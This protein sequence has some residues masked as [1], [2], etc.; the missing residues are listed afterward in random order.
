MYNHAERMKSDKYHN[1]T[2]ADG[3]VTLRNFLNIL[4]LHEADSFAPYSGEVVIGV[5]LLVE[6]S[7]RILVYVGEGKIADRIAYHRNDRRKPIFDAFFLAT[8]AGSA[9]WSKYLAVDMEARFLALYEGAF[10]CKPRCNR[11]FEHR[12]DAVKNRLS[13]RASVKQ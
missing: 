13:A 10:K 1:G 6:R 5:Y 8:E 11:K 4:P 2:I 7:T 3:T 9:E 12:V